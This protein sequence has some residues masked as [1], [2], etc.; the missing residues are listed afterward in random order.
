M[1]DD[2]GPALRGGE[3]GVVRTGAN[4]HGRSWTLAHTFLAP[5]DQ[6]VRST[7]LHH[8]LVS[9]TEVDRGRTHEE[10]KEVASRLDDWA[11]GTAGGVVRS[12][13]P[14]PP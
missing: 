14:F 11:P 5:M 3:K 1:D 2:G 7:N 9:G 4:F 8:G 6:G 10:K 12:A 13:G